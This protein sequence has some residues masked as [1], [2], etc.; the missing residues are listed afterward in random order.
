MS[1]PSPMM[2]PTSLMRRLMSTKRLYQ[3]FQRRR[4]SLSESRGT[5]SQGFA[6]HK[7][8]FATID[9][10]GA[11]FTEA[12]GINGKS[13]VRYALG[14]RY[15]MIGYTRVKT[16]HPASPATHSTAALH[17]PPQLPASFAGR[18]HYRRSDCPRQCAQARHAPIHET[19][20]SR[21]SQQ[22]D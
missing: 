8:T 19:A 9:P 10:P 11:L 5:G 1:N 16:P 7:G 17:I 3:A 15:P 20:F 21:A 18:V 6:L 14:F 12:H 22:R 13:S 4:K 2:K